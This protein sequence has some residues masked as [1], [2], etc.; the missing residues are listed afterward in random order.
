MRRLRVEHVTEF[1][2]GAEVQLLPHRLLMRPRE[3]H[4]VRIAAS[5]LKIEPA[6]T[7][8]WQRDIY[9]NSVALASFA[10]PTSKLRIAS[11]VDLEHYDETPFDFL[12]D[13]SALT[14][15]FAYS[16]ADRL[17]LE[18]LRVLL[19]PDQRQAIEAWLGSLSLPG[20][21][22][23]TFA[24]LDQLN[25]AISAQFR[26]LARDEEGV[27]PPA[28][29]L[30][31]GSGSCRDFATL[32]ME[33]CRCLGLAARFVSGYQTPQLT[34]VPGSTHAWADVYLPGPG[35]K[36][37]DPTAGLV[38]GNQHISAA[39]ARHPE[40]VPPVSGSFVGPPQLR[41]TMSVSVQVQ[42]VG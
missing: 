35:W 21:G 24:L 5:V 28:R 9:D 42:G 31:L 11:S 30:E 1:D 19:W 33:A 38:V 17:E 14:Y 10:L 26:Y 20:P 37:F 18:P 34:S 29:T 36:G 41:P 23:Q 15:P 8:R 22:M 32:F 3:S 39:V 4:S 12:V 7:I 13:E 25:R 27:Q 6:A 40:L 16:G 2:F